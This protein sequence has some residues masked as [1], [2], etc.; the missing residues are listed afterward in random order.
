MHAPRLPLVRRLPL[1]F[2]PAAAALAIAAWSP[3]A[4]AADEVRSYDITVGSD[5]IGS[6]RFVISKRD[7][8]S[9]MVTNEADVKVSVLWVKVTYWL[10]SYEIYKDGALQR[11]ASNCYDNGERRNV[12][13]ELEGDQLHVK[14]TGKESVLPRSVWTTSFWS[15][16]P[17]SARGEAQSFLDV[18]R[19]REQ[20]GTLKFVKTE[21]CTAGGRTFAC[22]QYHVHHDDDLD[23]WFDESD[24]LVRMERRK[25]TKRVVMQLT[26]VS[27]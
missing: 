19:G 12:E 27:H 23:L 24:R 6:A 20:G 7:D 16:P 26:S 21:Q 13:V 8:G 10:R 2:V 14:A 25:F 5:K 22:T 9:I 18:D 1:P 15:L 3:P 4:L 11:L 17:A